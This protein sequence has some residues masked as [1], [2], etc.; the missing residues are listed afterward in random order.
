MEHVVARGTLSCHGIVSALL[1]QDKY[2]EVL[3]S[4]V[5]QHWPDVISQVKAETERARGALQVCAKAA[6]AA[7]SGDAQDAPALAAQRRLLERVG[8]NETKLALAGASGIE[9]SK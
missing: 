4:C 1:Q 9:A 6:E 8:K 3:R 7:G 5:A 2:R